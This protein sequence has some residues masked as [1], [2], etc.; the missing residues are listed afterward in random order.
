MYRPLVKA[1]RKKSSVERSKSYSPQSMIF[2]SPTM[3]FNQV[4]GE[5]R[6]N[7][8]SRFLRLTA[9]EADDEYT[10]KKCSENY[11]IYLMTFFILLYH[12]SYFSFQTSMALSKIKF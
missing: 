4:N 10:H 5:R 11:H 1:L 6:L 3:C 2:T 9:V 12:V 8:Q 7:V